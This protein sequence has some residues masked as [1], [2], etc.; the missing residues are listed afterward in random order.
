MF[1]TEKAVILYFVRYLECMKLRLNKLALVTYSRLKSQNETEYQN[2]INFESLIK[3]NMLTPD[4]KMIDWETEEQ[5]GLSSTWDSTIRSVIR[6]GR[7]QVWAGGLS[8]V[9]GA[10]F[11]WKM[12]ADKGI[13][14]TPFSSEIEDLT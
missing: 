1:K 8:S 10:S 6:P 4:I 7:K 2:Q 11:C 12:E 9:S 13:K 14:Q 3:F 5:M